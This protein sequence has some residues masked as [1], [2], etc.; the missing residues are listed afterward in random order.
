[1]IRQ[2]PWKLC[3][4]RPFIYGIVRIFKGRQW[5]RTCCVRTGL[6][7]VAFKCGARRARHTHVISK[8]SSSKAQAQLLSPSKG[9]VLLEI[10]KT[11]CKWLGSAGSSGAAP[12]RRRRRRGTRHWNE[13]LTHRLMPLTP[14]VR[15][16]P[17]KATSI[18]HR[19]QTQA[20]QNRN[21]SQD[22]LFSQNK[23]NHVWRS[24]YVISSLDHFALTSPNDH[25]ANAMFYC[26]DGSAPAL[27][28]A[29]QSHAGNDIDLT[30]VWLDNSRVSV[31]SSRWGRWVSRA[32]IR[33]QLVVIDQHFS[34]VRVERLLL[35][36]HLADD[37]CVDSRCVDTR[38]DRLVALDVLSCQSAHR[39]AP[40]RTQRCQ[41]APTTLAL[42]VSTL[43]LR[44]FR[45]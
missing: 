31:R 37:A 8:Q 22:K 6:A 25:P 2:R 13:K 14:P 35:R 32:P 34:L 39:V 42:L 19:C 3:N 26:M 10:R 1:M 41:H 9:R 11:S 7:C 27:R 23:M 17:L 5:W 40:H 15:V 33:G 30:R 4:F 38:R 43:H 18:Q 44:Q 20:Y 36:T 16:P 28:S 29:Q 12:T 45:L 24:S 21:H